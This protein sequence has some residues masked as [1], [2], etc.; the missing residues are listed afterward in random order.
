MNIKINITATIFVAAALSSC[1]TTAPVEDVARSDAQASLPKIAMSWEDVQAV[2]GD[3][4][5]GWLKAFGDPVLES[6]VDEAQANN[7]NLQI[8]A[9]QVEQAR[10]LAKQAGAAVTPSVGISA[11]GQRS[12]VVDGSSASNL[13]VGLQANWELDVWGRVRSGSQ[14][15]FESARGAE[16]D[17]RFAQYSI[18][19]NVAKAYLIVIE[20]Q[21]QEQVAL[22]IQNALKE[23]DRIVQVQF[24]NGLA[25]QQDVSLAKADLATSEDTLVSARAGKRDALRALELLIGRYPGADLEVRTTLPE[26]P[27]APPAGIPAELLE[28]RPDLIASERRVAAAFNSTNAAKAARLPKIGLSAT[29]GG[30]STDLSDILNPANLAWTAATNLLAPLI[31]GGLG[32]A[33]V[34]AAT[35]EQDQAVAAYANAALT[36]FGEVEK[37]LDQAVVLKDRKAALQEAYAQAQQAYKIAQLRFDAGESDLLSVLQ[38]QQRVF[39]SESSLLSVE[40]EQLSQF[41]DVNLA[42]GGDWQGGS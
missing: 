23:L 32:K 20:A 9:A 25:T 18:A 39:G 24:D 40:R 7:K 26:Q 30:S 1:A 14:A 17:Y 29:L 10:A 35:A 8:A 22:N 19:G 4:Q 27:A 28:R 6:L 41:V 33:Q 5:V 3:V 11:G 36:A 42:L 38:I 37:A 12:G 21:L 31:D 15:A 34:E 16:A 13:S 2:V